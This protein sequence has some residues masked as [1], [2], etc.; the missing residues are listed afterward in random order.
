MQVWEI[1]MSTD[2]T[3]G[4]PTLW[5]TN[6]LSYALWLGIAIGIPI[7]WVSLPLVLG[8]LGMTMQFYR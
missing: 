1:S 7:G 2:Q 8:A 3:T 6:C 4:R 5:T